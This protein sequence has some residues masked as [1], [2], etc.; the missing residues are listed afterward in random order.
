MDVKVTW[1]RRYGENRLF[2]EHDGERLGWMDLRDGRLVVEQQNRRDEVYVA[3]ERYL[4]AKV[5]HPR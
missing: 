3:L 2:V 4:K 1:W 5:P